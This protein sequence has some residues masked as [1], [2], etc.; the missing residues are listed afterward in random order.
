MWW[1]TAKR[2][3]ILLCRINWCGIL[4]D[5]RLTCL[6]TWKINTNNRN[7]FETSTK[8]PH[9]S[10]RGSGTCCTRGNQTWGDGAGGALRVWG[11]SSMLLC[12]EHPHF[13]EL[14]AQ[15]GVYEVRGA[16]FFPACRQAA[17]SYPRA[18][19]TNIGWQLSLMYFL[20]IWARLAG[21]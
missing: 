9:A 17:F 2:S 19:I 6:C 13:K 8:A 16:L 14:A 15:R 4:P 20:I 12:M 18:Q 3:V 21:Y 11:S 1:G 7:P 5:G 10:E